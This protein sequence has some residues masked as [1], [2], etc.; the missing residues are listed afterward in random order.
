MAYIGQSLT[1]GTR[2]VYTYVATASQTTFNAVYGVGAV[3]VYQNGILLQPSD[4]TASDGTT[5]VLGVGAAFQDEITI[6]CHNTFSVADTVSASQGG[7]FNG[8]VDVAGDIRNSGVVL[9]Q[10]ENGGEV[11][12]LN[13][14][15]AIRGL[16][17]FGDYDNDGEGQLR[18]LNLSTDDG[19]VQIGIPVTNS[20]GNISFVTDNQERLRVDPNGATIVR[21]YLLVGESDIS[22]YQ[23]ITIR[24]ARDS[25]TATRTSFIDAQNNLAVADSHVFFGHNPD[26]G[27]Y[28]KFGTTPAGDRSTDRRIDRAIIGSEGTAHFYKG[29]SGYSIKVVNLTNTFQN[30]LG[31]DGALGAQGSGYCICSTHEN[32]YRQGWILTYSN[33][34]FHV[35]YLGGNEGHG[36]SQDVAFQ[37]S[38][39]YLQARRVNYTTGRPLEIFQVHGA[40]TKDFD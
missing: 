28:I 40:F 6:V 15:P 13:N 32:S 30:I 37:I 24:N 25:G 31:V 17:D 35:H 12:L 38:G 33:N 22:D 16:I 29:V 26:G 8:P 10:N 27:S 4:Y 18:F 5:V 14:N 2:R 9:T 21:N 34:I 11:Q 23:G 3:D 20:V 39:G 7:T 36:H 19:G 1:E